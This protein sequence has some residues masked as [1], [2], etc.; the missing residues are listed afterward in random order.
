MKCAPGILV[1]EKL[2]TKNMSRSAKGT[3]EQPGKNVKAKAGL[4]RSLQDTGIS[5]FTKILKDK[6]ESAGRLVIFVNPHNTSQICSGC[7]AKVP[8]TLAERRHRCVCGLDIDR[9]HN[10]A[11]NILYRGVVAAGQIKLAA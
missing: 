4:N 2:Q 5:Q 11:I 8:K 7:S 9:D 6:A 3:I 10:A 1:L